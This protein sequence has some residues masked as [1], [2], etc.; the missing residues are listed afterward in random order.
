MH[1]E[2]QILDIYDDVHL[3]ETL[4]KIAD[5]IPDRLK[6][7]EILAFEDR[8][9]Y[10]HGDFALCIIT[11][12][13]SFLRKFP[14]KTE[15]DTLLSANYLNLNQNKLPSEAIKTAAIKI[16]KACNKFNLPFSNPL[17]DL[18]E[19]ID[20]FKED[21][22]FKEGYSKKIASIELTK[23]HDE[24]L[25]Y[26]ALNDKYP[27]NTIE[28]IRTAE[29]YFHK[30]ASEFSPS[31][32]HEFS[33]NLVKRANVI[34]YEV[35]SPELNK[36]A[37]VNGYNP[38]LLNQLEYRYSLTNSPNCRLEYANLKDEVNKIHPLD[39]SEKL[40]KV[41][42]I[43]G[44]DKYYGK[45]IHDN[46]AATFSSIK[47]ADKQNSENINYDSL[48]S[49]DKREKLVS[50]LGDSFVKNLEENKENFFDTLSDDIK[51]LIILIDNGNI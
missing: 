36:Y 31:E 12:T 42:K 28:E 7:K 32:K 13:G 46:Y 34:G 1:L 3:E 24:N 23:N 48:L 15:L 41:D 22:L 21:N 51:E 8:L 4:I 2:Q 33:K 39:F 37:G 47:I 16:K 50:Y 40:A 43:S 49:K 26:K 38:N 45:R 19:G 10:N 44:L 6:N 14:I 11:K 17:I 25:S 20:S 18:L 35:E 27:I 5:S 30:Y 29:K 9:N